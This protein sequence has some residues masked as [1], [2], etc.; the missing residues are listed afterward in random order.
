[1]R[2]ESVHAALLM[3]VIIGLG[4]AVFAALES[5]IP[6]LQGVCTVSLFFS[7]SRVDSSAYTTTLGVQ[8]YFIGIAG[9]L[10]LL[11]LAIPLFRTWRRDLLKAVVGFSAVGLAIAA[12]F[13]YVELAVIHA[14]CLVCFSTYVADAAVLGLSLWLLRS[15]A[16]APDDSEEDQAGSRDDSDRTASS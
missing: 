10:I 4:L 5:V 15:S 16:S 6:A 1:M 8:D 12:Y 11:G 7:C 2:A 14:F 13:A 3:V 9:F